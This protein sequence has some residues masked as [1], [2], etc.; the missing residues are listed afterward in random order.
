MRSLLPLLFPFSYSQLQGG[1]G[2]AEPHISSSRLQ[3]SAC[4]VCKSLQSNGFVMLFLL[5]DGRLGWRCPRMIGRV[6]RK[7]RLVIAGELPRA[8]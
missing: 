7:D 8:M 2:V 3:T 6:V 5:Y 4:R 1:E